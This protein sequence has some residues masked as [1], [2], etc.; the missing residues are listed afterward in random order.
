M[1]KRSVGLLP[2]SYCQTYV[3]YGIYISDSDIPIYIGRTKVFSERKSNHFSGGRQVL[4]AASVI[5]DFIANTHQLKSVIMQMWKM[6][7]INLTVAPMLVTLC[8]RDAIIV[9]SR[10]IHWHHPKLNSVI[11][12]KKPQY[13]WRRNPSPPPVE[14]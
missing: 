8:D 9:E 12:K 7:D 14:R 11:M 1:N 6:G 2:Y 5:G 3:V 13:Q 4:N 10:M